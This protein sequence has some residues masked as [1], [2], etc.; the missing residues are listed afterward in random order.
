MT[1]NRMKINFALARKGWTM[2]SFAEACGLS[3]G[4]LHAILNAKH[5][6]PQTAGRLAAALGVDVA[7]IVDMDE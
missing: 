7:E 3:R 2:G 1:I 5:I 6:M 4:R